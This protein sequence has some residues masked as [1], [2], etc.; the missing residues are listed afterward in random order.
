M[1]K[2]VVIEKNKDIPVLEDEAY[3]HSFKVFNTSLDAWSH[4]LQNQNAANYLVAQIDIQIV[5][6]MGGDSE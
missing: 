6:R 4:L 3:G 1:L 5:N 2:F